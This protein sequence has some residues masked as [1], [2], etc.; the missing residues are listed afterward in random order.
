MKP[1]NTLRV[2]NAEILIVEVGVRRS[3]DAEKTGIKF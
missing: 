2:Q 3:Y 1:I